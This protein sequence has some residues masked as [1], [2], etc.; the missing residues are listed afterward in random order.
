M[1]KITPTYIFGLSF[2]L[3]AITIKGTDIA[4][5]E[6]PPVPLAYNGRIP[7]GS[8]PFLYI[9]DEVNDPSRVGRVLIGASKRE[10]A[11]LEETKLPRETRSFFITEQEPEV[12]FLEEVAVKSASSGEERLVA[13]NLVIHPGQAL[14][15]QV[16]DEFYSDA[17][18]KV[19][20]YYI[21]LRF[22]QASEEDGAPSSQA[23]N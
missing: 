11:R 20:G 16:A 19:R 2:N 14:E 4:V 1:S 12:T 8:C 18:L 21:P 7:Q 17:I 22:D 15:F 10:F 5:R 6:A 23:P 13:S 9:S 3:K